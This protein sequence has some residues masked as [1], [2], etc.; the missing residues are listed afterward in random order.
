MENFCV[1]Q[2]MSAPDADHRSKAPEIRV[3]PPYS[4]STGA[5]GWQGCEGLSP[6]TKDPA[7]GTTGRVKL[8]G[9]LGWMGAR[10]EY[11]LDGEGLPLP[12]ILVAGAS[13]HVQA[14]GDFF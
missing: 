8:Y 7:G 10:A 12:P 3:Y 14:A 6:K 9:R 13:P 2:P 11:S 5:A 4:Q 1:V